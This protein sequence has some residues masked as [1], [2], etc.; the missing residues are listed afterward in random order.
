MN[1]VLVTTHLNSRLLGFGNI[2]YFMMLFL[3]ENY[4]ETLFDRTKICSSKVAFAL[5][6]VLTNSMVAHMV[7]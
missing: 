5:T 1:L 2:I 3:G 7:Y 6:L 4:G